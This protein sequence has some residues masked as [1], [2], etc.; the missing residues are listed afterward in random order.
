VVWN[1]GNG[2]ENISE[3]TLCLAGLV[4]GWSLSS[5]RQITCVCNQPPRP[6]QPPALNGTG[7]EYQ[8]MCKYAVLL[9]VN[10]SMVHCTVDVHVGAR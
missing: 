10:S 1:S 4:L 8:P 5:Q 6:T 2:G 3:I 9:G 7:N